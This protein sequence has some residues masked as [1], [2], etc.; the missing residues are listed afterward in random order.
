MT[1]V[2]Y[3]RFREL[4]DRAE[5]RGWHVMLAAKREIFTRLMVQHSRSKRQ[6]E[7]DIRDGDLERAA[8]RIME[9]QEMR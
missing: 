1:V 7:V 3:K 9:S 8:K 2:V 4:C 5:R 6:I